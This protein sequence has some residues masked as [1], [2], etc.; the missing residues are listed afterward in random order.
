MNWRSAD[1]VCPPSGIA[2]LAQ[3]SRCRCP[4]IMPGMTM[5]PGSSI[6]AA[7]WYFSCDNAFDIATAY[8]LNPKQGYMDAML[9]N[10]NYEGGCNPVNVTFVTGLGWKRNREIVNQWAPLDREVLPPSGIPVGNIAA[11]FFYLSTYGTEVE[12]LVYPGDNAT[13]APYPYYDRWQ[14]GWNVSAE[15]TIQNSARALGTLSM[16]AAQGTV[17][18]Q[19]W[20]SVA[21]TINVPANTVPL[22]QPVTVSLQAPAGVDLSSARIVWEARD[23]EPSFGSTFTFTPSNSGAQWVEAEA[24]LPDGRRVFAKSSFNANS[25]SVAWLDDALPPG[26][27]LGLDGE[28]WNWVSSNPTPN[29]GSLAHQSALMA[30]VHQHYFYN[31]TATL[32]VNTGDLLY[33]WVYLD[34][35]N[36]PS[37]VMVQWNDGTSWDHRA[38]WGANNIA[39]G[40]NGTASQFPMGPLPAAGQWVQL[41]VQ[42][43]KVGLEGKTLNGM[44]FT[45]YGGRATWDSAGRIT[46][47]Q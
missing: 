46:P 27:L 40:V 29:S 19:A 33:A 12:E 23:Q 4:L 8:A 24:Q 14:D 36:L 37:E 13:T 7:G 41:S 39:Y 18:T 35:A 15:F 20:K 44:A 11:S 10:M 32:A 42:A 31:S 47:A 6:S 17:K 26:A 9:A 28:T 43:S 3:H 16:L 45:L 1:S 5:L 25:P 2:P 34:P 38:Y 30:G 22:N 21:A